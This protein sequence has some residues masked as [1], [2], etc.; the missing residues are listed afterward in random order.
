MRGKRS[1]DKIWMLQDRIE[2]KL[3]DKYQKLISIP[4]YLFLSFLS[5]T[6][7]STGVTLYIYC[8]INNL[9]ISMVETFSNPLFYLMLSYI[10]LI[11][12]LLLKSE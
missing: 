10:L 3:R 8:I 7:L 2:R 9:D 5:F 4:D 12:A 6:F 1:V 11:V